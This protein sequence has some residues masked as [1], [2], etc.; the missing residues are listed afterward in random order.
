[1]NLE[2]YY[3]QQ[4]LID[5]SQLR[6]KTPNTV[7]LEHAARFGIDKDTRF[8]G[9]PEWKY[10][11]RDLQASAHKSYFAFSLFAMVCNDLNMHA[12]FHEHYIKF[13]ELTMYPKFGWSGFGQVYSTPCACCHNT[14]PPY[15]HYAVK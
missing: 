3:A 1:M 15:P 8:F 5:L 13:R 12:N 4:F 11:A 14:Q 7:I 2:Q 6:L 10:C 9:G